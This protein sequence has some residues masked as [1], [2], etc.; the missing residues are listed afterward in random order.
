MKTYLQTVE[1]GREA[2]KWVLID[3]TNVP[4]GR[5]A[6]KVATIIRGK[7]RAQFTPSVDGGDFVVVINAGKVGLTG[8]KASDKM[9]FHHTGYAGGIKSVSAGDLRSKNP[10]RLIESAVIGMLPEGILGHRMQKKLKV[11]AGSEHPHAAQNPETI[12]A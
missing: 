2:A 10:E 12:K 6:T 3:A 7:H 4:V 11:Y 8:K 9:L 1:Q 5:L